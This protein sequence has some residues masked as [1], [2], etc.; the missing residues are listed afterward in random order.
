MTRFP[1]FASFS[2]VVSILAWISVARA[3]YDESK[4]QSA[5][6]DRDA[7]KLH[8]FPQVRDHFAFESSEFPT[9]DQ[10]VFVSDARFKRGGPILFY[11]GNEADVELYV[12]NTGLM[13]EN[14]RAL[15]AKLV[16]AEHRF[17]GESLLGRECSLLTTAQALADYAAIAADLRSAHPTSPIFG[18]GGSY[19]GM[20]ATWMRMKYPHLI[21]GVVAAS[22]PVLASEGMSD[23]RGFAKV[24]TEVAA[25]EGTSTCPKHVNR[26]LKS[27]ER[28]GTEDLSSLTRLVKSCKRLKPH[29]VNVVMDTL[30]DPFGYYAMG[31]FP[32]PSD[33]MC[34]QINGKTGELPAFP[35][36]S[37][38]GRL[39]RANGT[40]SGLVDAALMLYNAS[41]TLEC[42]DYASEPEPAVVLGKLSSFRP[43]IRTKN[44]ETCRGD[45]GRQFC[46]DNLLPAS[47]GVKGNDMFYPP[48][49]FSLEKTSDACF[50]SYGVRPDARYAETQYGGLKGIEALTRV[51][52]SNGGSD[53]WRAGGVLKHNSKFDSSIVII[54]MPNGG[55][56]SD[57]FFSNR[58]DFPDVIAARR[59]EIL[60]LKKWIREIKRSRFDETKTLSFS[61]IADDARV[62]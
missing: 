13:W 51:I 36:R 25:K 2:F 56:H 18:F 23:P 12:N 60:T 24:V 54:D 49:V 44:G 10:R 6:R 50:E 19:G 41:G 40:V 8:I 46:T 7:V 9:F 61:N 39:A 17:Y 53:P 33:Y 58:A 59:F 42:M 21:A 11:F 62:A 4:L 1:S 26:A 16:F 34:Q 45:W 28:M 15:R 3:S 29:D 30:A 55:H 35:M 5:L 22:A 31:N 27:V 20:L 48:S 32:F 57:L 38:C 43:R 52:F 14:A 37:A 47:Q